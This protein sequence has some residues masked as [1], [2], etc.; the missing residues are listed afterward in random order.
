M[1]ELS[2]NAFT[3]PLGDGKKFSNQYEVLSQINDIMPTLN[4]KVNVDNLN[5]P[6]VFICYTNKKGVVEFRNIMDN[7]SIK[8]LQLQ[9]PI[10]INGDMREYRL[11]LIVDYLSLSKDN[12]MS[13]A[14]DVHKYYVSENIRLCVPDS[15]YDTILSSCGI[16]FVEFSPN[17]ECSIKTLIN[18]VDDYEGGE[19]EQVD[20]D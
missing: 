20:A 1:S 8:V 9:T 19:H 14:R 6:D 16:D 18:G 11:S 5:N 3:A 4:E 12:L 13:L 15:C 17:V 10:N 7:A 2:F